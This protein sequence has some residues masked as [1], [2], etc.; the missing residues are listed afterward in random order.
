[1]SLTRKDLAATVV[2]ALAVLV[3]VANTN[4][5]SGPLLASNRWASAAVLVLGV[6]GCS[7]GRPA[8]DGGSATTVA[9]SLLG[10]AALLLFAVAMWTGAQWA[11]ALLTLDTVVLWAASTL[12]HVVSARPATPH[13]A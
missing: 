4:E 11:L 10:G 3:Y 7:L 8:E 5:W 2:A 13:P 12:R 1:M 6:V 9:L